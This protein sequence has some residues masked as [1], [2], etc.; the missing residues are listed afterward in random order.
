MAI[1]VAI[2]RS[3]TV[4]ESFLDRF[5][6][7][8]EEPAVGT[9]IPEIAVADPLAKF[10]SDFD[11]FVAEYTEVP[12]ALEDLRQV[13]VEVRGT[14]PPEHEAPPSRPATLPR[15][16]IVN[17]QA[18]LREFRRGPSSR[19]PD[20]LRHYLEGLRRSTE[21]RLSSGNG[22]GPRTP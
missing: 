2:A 6:T 13:L 7:G 15:A 4:L 22:G 18:M 5:R 3:A 8:R 16:R 21:G 17:L 10:W 12:S 20:P 1:G 9:F 11:L 14:E 19:G